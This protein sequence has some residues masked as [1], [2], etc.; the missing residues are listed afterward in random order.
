MGIYQSGEDYLETIYILLRQKPEVHAVDVANELNFSK[1][2]VTRAL[3]ILKE[4]GLLLID[5]NNHLRLT[6]EGKARAEAVYE[7]H[8]V[9][10]KLLIHIGVSEE[11]A[12]KDA[13]RLE[14]HISEE[15]YACMK[16]VLNKL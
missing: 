13:C 15:T 16:K 2:S 8:V 12:L 3:R 11:T 5:E 6:R 4:S 7:R 1:P 14:H 9:I 10:S